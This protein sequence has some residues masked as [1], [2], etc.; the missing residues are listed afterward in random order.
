MSAPR[1]SSRA[2]WI[3]GI[4][5]EITVIVSTIVLYTAITSRPYIHSQLLRYPTTTILGNSR[6]ED[7]IL[8]WTLDR[9]IRVLRIQIWMGNP[10]GVEWEGDV[11]VTLGKPN[12]PWNPD[13]DQ[14]L[15][16]LQFDSHAPTPTPS[17]ICL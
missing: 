14:L 3:I 16:H 4:I 17:S 15:A 12:D 10:S 13:T 8:N 5:I 9:D 11:F 7:W 1:T 2:L 6:V